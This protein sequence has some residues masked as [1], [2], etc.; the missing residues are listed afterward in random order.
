M[1][2]PPPLPPL[3]VAAAVRA[4]LREDLG[5]AGDITSAAT[6]PADAV[7]EAVFGARQ[8]GVLA[9]LALAEAAFREMDPAVVF[10]AVK[11][12]GDRI[13]KGDVA[14]RVRGSA[15][16]ILSA[17]RVA[18]NYLCHLSGV[19]TATAAL[20]AEVAH[21]KARICD[22]RKTLPGLR[23]L[24][25]YAVRCGGG[26]N[27]RYGLDD[28]ILIKDNHIAVAGGVVR[29]IERARAQAGHMVRIEVEVDSLAMLREALPARPDAVLLD[30][31]TPPTLR[32]AVALVA[33]Q[34][35]TEASGGITLATVAA[36]AET[37]VDYISSGWI[38]HSAPSL[39]LGLD[40]TTR[41]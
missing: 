18:L 13:G 15:R 23:A 5:R 2:D 7:A 40:I 33:G 24:E 39:D 41:I 37:G 17:E 9:G 10:I 6:I 3:I 27:H 36:V 4:A 35:I 20:V 28:A 14:A 1:T 31:M 29:A 22:T 34:A 12:D 19:A 30:N 11:R 8:E 26:W 38:T 16:A 21:T 25:K 32:E